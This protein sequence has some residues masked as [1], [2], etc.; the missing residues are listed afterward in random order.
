MT[1]RFV[2]PPGTMTMDRDSRLDDLYQQRSLADWQRAFD[3]LRIMV[4]NDAVG[5]GIAAVLGP[6]GS[7]SHSDEQAAEDAVCNAFTSIWLR[8]R[9][10]NGHV[11]GEPIKDVSGF[12][13]IVG[14]CKAFDELRARSP[15]HCQVRSELRWTVKGSAD[16]D[17]WTTWSGLRVIGLAALAPP[18]GTPGAELLWTD[19]MERARVDPVRFSAEFHCDGPLPEATGNLLRA[20]GGVMLANDVTAFFTCIRLHGDQAQTPDDLATE[21]CATGNTEMDV[22][23]RADWEF[24]WLEW[25]LLPMH[26]RRASGLA[27]RKPLCPDFW[28][29]ELTTWTEIAECLEMNLTQIGTILAADSPDG[30]LATMIHLTTRQVVNARQSGLERLQRRLQRSN[31]T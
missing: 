8:L 7:R 16:L 21:T 23:M 27:G 26:Q 20:V 2:P 11:P 17:A 4:L 13:W 30:V 5:S 3:R 15:H 9:Q 25:Q 10:S 12:A 29:L 18:K 22:V 1:D 24:V 6:P 19:G 14:R 28:D 31:K